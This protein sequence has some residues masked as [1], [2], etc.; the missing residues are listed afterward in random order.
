MQLLLQQP[1]IID[2][3]SSHHKK[4]RD[5]LIEE[6]QIT[7]ITEHISPDNYEQVYSLEGQYV[8]PGWLDTYA[9]LGDPGYEYKEDL[10]SSCS[11]AAHGGFTGVVCLPTTSPPLHS[12]SEIEY[13]LNKSGPYPVD[14]WPL[15]S[16]TRKGEGDSLTEMYDMNEAGAIA[17]SEGNYPIASTEIMLQALQY[18]KPFEGLIYNIPQ[19]PTLAKNSVMHEGPVSTRLGL[20]GLPNIAEKVMIQRDLELLRYTHSRLHYPNISTAAGV[21]LIKSAKAEGLSITAGVSP[22]Q[23]IFQDEALTTF[24]TRYKVFPPLRTKKDIE[25]LKE[26]IAE[27]I[28]DVFCTNHQP[29]EAE[30]KE[31]EFNEA[32]FGMIH[33]ETAFS[34]AY[35]YLQDYLSIEKL[36]E[37]WA[38]R[39]YELLGMPPPSL[40]SHSPANLTIFNPDKR[41]TVQAEDLHS[42]SSNSPFLGTT[43][44]GKVTGIIN[45]NKWQIFNPDS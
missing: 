36:I 2:P 26:G 25:A 34:A 16:I 29:H 32:A 21:K 45:E 24:D 20:P 10:Q 37:K 43:L 7:K 28:I 9:F 15:G 41:W 38:V 8:S 19:D 44:Q 6:G 27:G 18:V 5:L 30:V 31:V 35:T 12:K 14:V 42:K 39:P 40:T 33:L 3:N 13:I 4:E 1:T 22:Y 11:A 23:L 17:F